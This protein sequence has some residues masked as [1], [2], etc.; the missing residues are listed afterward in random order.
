MRHPRGG[1][2]RAARRR[3]FGRV[4]YV[5]LLIF[6]HEADQLFGLHRVGGYRLTG[7]SWGGGLPDPPS[8]EKEHDEKGK[9]VPLYKYIHVKKKRS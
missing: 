8:P 1:L 7:G 9:D 4:E 2:Y 5:G 3:F 6:P